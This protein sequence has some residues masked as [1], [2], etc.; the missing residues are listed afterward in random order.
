MS[1]KNEI[2]ETLKRGETITPLEALRDFGCMRLSARIGELE[3]DGWHINS[4]PVHLDRGKTVA[5][6]SLDMSVAM[7]WKSE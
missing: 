1:Q 7:T 2:L 4:R 5:G 3:A 6:Y